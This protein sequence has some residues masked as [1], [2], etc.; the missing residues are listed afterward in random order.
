MYLNFFLIITYGISSIS[1]ALAAAFAVPSAVLRLS[2][3]RS[4]HSSPL[5]AHRLVAAP[6]PAVAHQCTVGGRV[7]AT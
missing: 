1:P 3:Q 2:L 7:E 6:P 5:L 4:L